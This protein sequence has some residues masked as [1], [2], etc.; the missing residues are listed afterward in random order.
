MQELSEKIIK[1]TGWMLIEFGLDGVTFVTLQRSNDG[2]SMTVEL[3][4]GEKIMSI[5]QLIYLIR[6]N[7][8]TTL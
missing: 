1:E 5:E 7:L 3:Q 6:K 8:N 2:C 4:F